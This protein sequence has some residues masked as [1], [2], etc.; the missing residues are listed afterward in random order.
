MPNPNRNRVFVSYSHKDNEWLDKLRTVLAPDIRNDRVDYWDDREL[1]PGDPWYAKIID[2][3]SAA[4]V[5]VLLV[6][7][8]FLASRFIMEEEV[9]R[10][11]KAVDDGLTIIWI[12]IFGTFYGPGAP[13]QI[14]PLT[15]VQAAF[16]AGK[17]LVE[18]DPASQT[19]LLIGLCRHIHRLLNPNRIPCNLPF[20]SLA[21]L[22]KGRDE[23]LAQLDRSL[24]QHGSAAIVQPQA[25]HGL[26]GIG[27]TRLAIEYAWRHQNDFTAFLFVSANTPD[28]LDRNVAALCRPD[29]VDLREN[30]SPKQDE[31]R[32]AV[33]R[34][35]QQNRG[36]LLILDNVD[37]DEGVRAVKTLAAKLRG[38][39][40]LI[41]SRMTEWGRGVHPLALDVLSLDDA[42]ALLLESAHGWRAPQPEDAAEGRTLAASLGCLPLALTHATAY[43]QHHHQGFKAYLNDFGRHF[44]RIL[45]YVDHLAIEYETELAEEGKEPATPEAKAARKKIVKTLATTFFL[46]F[47]RLTPEAKA[48]LQ[49]TAFLAPAPISV[50]M[51]E[52]SPQEM[53]AL[54]DLW[55]EET[56]EAKTGQT[57]GDAVAALA[58]YSLISRSEGAFSVHRM[59]QEK[60]IHRRIPTGKRGT[61]AEAVSLLIA[62]SA[63]P[64]NP[65]EPATWLGWEGL[66]PH[67]AHVWETI[68]NSQ[69]ACNVASLPQALG[70][71][72]YGKGLYDLGVSYAQQGLSLYEASRGPDASETLLSLS[73]LA[74]LVYKQ[75]DYARAEPL[76][77][78]LVDTSVRVP[79]PM[80]PDT[81]MRRNGQA[82]CIEMK[83]GFVASEPLYRATLADATKALGENHPVTLDTAD[84]FAGALLVQGK[85]AE[86]EPILRRVL[87]GRKQVLGEDHWQSCVTMNNLA[88]VLNA[89][90]SRTE[91]GNLYQSALARMEKAIGGEH[92]D[93]LRALANYAAFLAE[94]DQ[95]TAE[96]VYRRVLE[97]R[98]RRLGLEH[99]E[100]LSALENLAALL[101]SK[102][103]GT[104]LVALYQHTLEVRE[105]VLGSEHAST[106]A[107]IA[108]L[109]D[110]LYRL[111][112]DAGAEA[113]DRRIVESRERKFGSA[114]STVAQACF[115]YACTLGN[116]G[117]AP[118]A[119]I[120]FRRSLAVASNA[121]DAFP[122]DSP[123]LVHWKNHLAAALLIQDK[124][125][126]ATQVC[127][128]CWQMQAGRKDL[129]AAR[130]L[131]VRTALALLLGHPCHRFLGQLKA[132]CTSGP[133]PAPNGVP[134]NWRV[135][136]VVS[137]LK[138][139]LYQHT[140]L[141][142]ALLVALNNPG[143][144]PAL[145]QFPDWHDQVPVPLDAAWTDNA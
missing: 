41:T 76:F 82:L 50:A 134:V 77:R 63:P 91:A 57:V 140:D 89:L 70:L 135:P 116:L 141:L 73:N 45:D 54:V 78:R 114:H 136:S 38:G 8:N 27:K 128:E 49:S 22:F 75:Q 125:T 123:V 124:L 11:L 3:I 110:L 133:L 1:Q 60:I 64:V 115:N 74:D 9:P 126:E 118:E 56:N 69:Q 19:A 12:P 36:W 20:T 34:W 39:H 62:R 72:C 107:I 10:I 113:L 145:E 120:M 87:A 93:Y 13:P 31:Q 51:F 86:A 7:P 66:Q 52:Q 109:S 35:L 26:G 79:G 23:A 17:P 131:Y 106:E 94:T 100:T 96:K 97:C 46:S 98:E 59:L 95:T 68:E 47:D 104:G 137:H 130:I 132:L 138:S 58:R 30:Q 33:I 143:E 29:C 111:G 37:T 108:G 88:V 65:H 61:W 24:R 53:A 105:R 92:P 129:T 117:R 121:K 15:D 144:I 43:M 90:G 32:D 67:A 112:D 122:S 139:R 40:V 81:L 85:N 142:T 21:E 28:D 84:N 42:V 5:A 14:K 127:A 83:D 25:I 18:Q 2:G 44:E 102:G 6:S 4:R 101:S 48:I 71:L 55:C 119:E 99:P 80:H 103:D 16:D